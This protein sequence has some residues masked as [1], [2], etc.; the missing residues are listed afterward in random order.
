MTHREFADRYLDESLRET[1]LQRVEDGGW[2]DD[3]DDDTGERHPCY[4][5]EGAFDWSKTPE[6]RDFWDALARAF[7]EKSKVPL[8][9]VCNKYFSPPIT[10]RI[11]ANTKIHLEVC[12]NT[13]QSA[14][15][16]DKHKHPCDIINGFSW[17]SSPEGRGYWEPMYD[18]WC[19]AA[20]ED[21]DDL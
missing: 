11:I 13:R 17:D 19:E 12:Y 21:D 10:E 5:L 1:Y 18:Y 16:A 6:G 7:E 3:V 20:V 9:F 14:L 15:L 8:I 2:W 4:V